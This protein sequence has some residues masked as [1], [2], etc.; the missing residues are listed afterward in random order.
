EKGLMMILT[1][2]TA[3]FRNEQEITGIDISSMMDTVI[4]LRF[5][6]IGGEINRMLMIMKSRGQKASNQ[7]REF[8]ITDHGIDVL[9][10]YV[11]GGGVLTGTA[12]QEQEAKEAVEARRKQMEIELKEYDIKQKRAEMEAEIAQRRAEL[13][14]AEAELKVMQL[15]ESLVRGGR[16]IRGKIRGED[17]NSLRLK[18]RVPQRKQRGT[19]RKEGTK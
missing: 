14:T 10:V 11:G 7:Y 17:T 15:E 12:R 19:T 16:D 18:K 13:E 2:Q 1:N 3:G 9:D 4:F 5:V 6:E 8:V